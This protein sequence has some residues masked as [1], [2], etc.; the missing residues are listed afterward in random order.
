MIASIAKDA[1]IDS[2]SGARQAGSTGRRNTFNRGGVAWVEVQSGG[3]SWQGEEQCI[4]QAIGVR[5]IAGPRQAPFKGRNKPGCGDPR[6]VNGWSPEQIAH[7]LQ[8]DFPDDESVRISH[9]TIYQALDTHRSGA[10][11]RELVGCLRTGRALRVPKAR[12]G[13]RQGAAKLHSSFDAS[14]G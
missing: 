12:P 9:E 14:V 8:I 2:I 3:I 10:L 13:L 11:K 4:L 6:W 5:E 1:S 7:R